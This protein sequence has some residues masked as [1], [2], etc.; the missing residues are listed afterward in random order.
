MGNFIYFDNAATTRTDE[1][2]VEAMLPYFSD[3]YGNPSAAYSLAS[4]SRRA[5]NNA[6][7]SAAAMLHCDTNEIF[8]TSGGTEAD[9]LAIRGIAENYAREH[10]G[11]IGSIISTRIEHHAVLRT[12]DEMKR[13]GAKIIY[14]DTD[15]YGT[16]N[17]D[18]IKKSV[19]KDTFLISVMTANNEVGTIEPVSEIGAFARDNNILFHTDA[20]QAFGQIPIDVREMKADLLSAS[21]HKCYGPQGIGIL[22]IRSGVRI[23]SQ[24]TG[25]MQERGRRAGTE[26]V[27]AIAG[28]GAA[29]DIAA[30]EM[31]ERSQR[32]RAIC[33]H[34][35]SEL[36]GSIE[37]CTMNGPE[38][39]MQ[40]LPG[41]INL[42]F[43][44]IKGETLVIKLDME[45]ICVS[46]GSACSTGSSDPS[47]VLTAMGRTVSQADSA[48]RITAGK[49]NTMEE[50]D[51]LIEKIRKCVC[52]MRK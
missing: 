20:V 30:E 4:D 26:N 16:V 13:L 8:F 41:N 7:N 28:F 44:G 52:Q 9:N 18:D 29:M 1:H 45:G 19:Q 47:H 10:E 38:C 50:A 5:V 42:A 17:P 3:I 14:V 34:I 40:R 51:I 11:R 46:S 23:A 25:G 32:E 21:G 37:G 49:Y 39:G 22:Y 43:D 24:M 31:Q 15:S 6:R 27:P 48:I 33:A 36:R 2:V 12:L 35:A